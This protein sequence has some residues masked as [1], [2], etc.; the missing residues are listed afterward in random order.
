M[1]KVLVLGA[2][3]VAG[4]LVEYLL[5]LPDVEVTVASRTVEKAQE[6]IGGHPQGN[7]VAFNIVKDDH[8]DELVSKHDVVISLLPYTFHLAVARSC[9]KNKKDMV[10]TSYISEEMRALD[11]AAKNANITILNELGLDP[12]I[13][14]MEAMRIIDEVKKKGGKVKSFVSYCGGL[15]APECNDNPLGYKFSWSPRGVL[16]AG[17]NQARFKKNGEIVDVG[18][19]ELF[20]TTE[21]VEVPEMGE[22][23][24]Y[25]NRD[26]VPYAD[27]Y[28]I[29]DVDTMFRGTLR[30]K[31]WCKTMKK[32]AELGYLT[33][34]EMD[35]PEGTTWKELTRKIAGV[36]GDL[37]KGVAEKLGLAKDSPVIER[38]EWIG[39]FSDE[40][41]PSFKD[42]PLDMLSKRIEPMMK[43][44][45]GERDMIVLQ[46]EF[47]AEYSDGKKEKIIS[48]LVDYGEPEGYSAMART[49]SLPAA[50]GTK[51]LLKGK[52]KE[53]G[54]IGPVTPD[55]YEPALEELKEMGIKFKTIKENI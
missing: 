34:D 16:L 27:H 26:S 14:H 15:P 36:E 39:L 12:G 18:N 5:D 23:V 40:K 53:K 28:G 24:G 38:M 45:K 33:L 7:A 13:D 41:L 43:Y 54:V 52:V 47:I 11:P 17:R 29:P 50:I 31:G 9:I 42:A 1:K 6:L 49:V 20:E 21:P 35:L 3:L 55:I 4:P 2:G 25:P 32:L 48:Y 8:I 46:H 44:C 37:K 19:G 51:L 30:Y 10:T 22:F